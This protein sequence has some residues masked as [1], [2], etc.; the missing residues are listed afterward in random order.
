MDLC[1][2]CVHEKNAIFMDKNFV[3]ENSVSDV[4]CSNVVC[5]YCQLIF[6]Y[7]DQ[8]IHS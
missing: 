7:L 1:E 6:V 5:T 2:I 8:V 3:S 4:V